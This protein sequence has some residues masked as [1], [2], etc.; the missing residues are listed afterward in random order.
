MAWQTTIVPIVRGLIFDVISPYTYSDERLEEIIIVASILTIQEVDFSITY[1]INIES[2][3]ISPDPS[4]DT[5]FLALVSLKTACIIGQGEHRTASRTSIAVK[6]GPSSIDNRDSAKNLGA[7]ASSMCAT[8]SKAKFAYQS[9]DI[10]VGKAIVGPYNA[11][12]VN[13]TTERFS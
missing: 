8:Y 2:Q 10:S 6:D 3:T 9:G 11:G 7:L 1:T 12:Q 4:S 5:S 13:D